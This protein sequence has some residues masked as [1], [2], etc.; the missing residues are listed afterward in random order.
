MIL[1]IILMPRY[2]YFKRGLSQP[3]VGGRGPVVPVGNEGS[4]DHAGDG[5]GTRQ[6]TVWFEGG[7]AVTCWNGKCLI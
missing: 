2:S 3:G 6:R 1:N 5:A 4:V 7:T